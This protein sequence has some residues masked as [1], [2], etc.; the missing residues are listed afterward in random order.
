MSGTPKEAASPE[1]RLAPVDQSNRAALA[2]MVLGPAQ[3]HFVASNADS[4]A[5]AEEDADARP[6]ALLSGDRLVGFLMYEAPEGNSE[7]RIYR[8]MIDPAEQGHG[9]GRAAVRAVLAE[10]RAIGSVTEVSIC[11]DPGNEAAR[12]LYREAGFREEGLD[13]DG[14]M[15]ARLV[16]PTHEA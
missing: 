15:I 3:A 12:R 14:E 10:I 4:L 5:E 9:F 11:Y 8:L 16:W 1:L 13:E 7:A 2:A 6:R